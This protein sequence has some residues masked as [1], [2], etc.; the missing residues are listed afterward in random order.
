MSAEHASQND[1]QAAC[2][3]IFALNRF[4]ETFPA[5]PHPVAQDT[6]HNK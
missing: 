3:E 2:P 4:S 6:P 1:A 5:L